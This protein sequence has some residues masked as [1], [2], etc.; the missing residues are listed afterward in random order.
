MARAHERYSLIVDWSQNKR[1]HIAV[2]SCSVALIKHSGK[3]SLWRKGW[4]LAHR[5]E[6]Q[7]IM[8]G[9]ARKQENEADDHTL[10]MVKKQE[11][12]RQCSAYSYQVQDPFL[13]WDPVPNQDKSSHIG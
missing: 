7:S 10:F 1:K 9:Q 5:P 11:R 6:A 13:L 3:S 12:M 2:A 8:A 4:V